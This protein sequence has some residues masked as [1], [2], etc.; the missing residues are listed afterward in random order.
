MAQIENQTLELKIQDLDSFKELVSALARWAEEAAQK[1]DKTEA[2]A[3]LFAAAVALAD[4]PS[5]D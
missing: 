5:K 3:E 1:T 2:E 4:S